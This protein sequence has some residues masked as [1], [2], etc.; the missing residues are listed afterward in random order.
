MVIIKGIIFDVDETLVY[1]EGYNSRKWF[2][3][4]G[5]PEIAELGLD[6]D[7]ETYR[8][9]VIGELPRSYVEVF[10][11]NHVEFWKAIDEA[12]L[13]YRK[14][15]AKEGKIKTFPD[16]DAL[17]ELKKFG[18]KLAAVSNASQECTEFVLELFDLKKYFDVVFGKDY[19]YLDGAKPNPY[20][21]EKALKA[22]G[23]QPNE[24]L[25]VGDSY[26]DVLAAHRA[27]VKA[28]QA[29]RFDNFIGEADYHVK[30][31]WEL[32]E[33]VMKKNSKNKLDNTI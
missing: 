33:L 4:W 11:V 3:K 12:K 8:K 22:L 21:I 20:L 2:E 25:V 16:V 23:V 30:D 10:G 19:S 5:K 27:N 9:M 13:K 1:Y 28:V 7:F 31:L 32:W 29:L 6:L 15:A 24:A 14:A 17:G 26:S 18:L